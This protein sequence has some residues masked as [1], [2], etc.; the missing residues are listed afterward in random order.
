MGSEVAAN[1][2]PGQVPYD[3]R[4]VSQI[5]RV[6]PDIRF[7]ELDLSHPIFHSFFDSNEAYRLGVNYIVYGLTH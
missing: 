5:R 3:G 2:S 4:F 1:L 7:V 6:L